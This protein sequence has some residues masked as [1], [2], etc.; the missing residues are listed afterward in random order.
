MSLTPI[1]P[2]PPNHGK[3]HLLCKF[4]AL[5]AINGPLPEELK[6]NENTVKTSGNVV[7]MLA[8][9]SASTKQ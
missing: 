2:P 8:V 4:F 1:S 9:V 5:L 6:F 3:V 7:E